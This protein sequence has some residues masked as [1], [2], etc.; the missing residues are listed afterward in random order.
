VTTAVLVLLAVWLLLSAANQ[1]NGPWTRLLGPLNSVSLLP[2]LFFF[3]PDP[4]DVDYHLVFRDFMEDGEAGRWQQIPIER[5]GPWRVLW[6]TAKR[7]HQAM[8]LAVAGLAGLQQTVTPVARDPEGL[9]QVSIPY[10]F[11][12]HRV[13][14]APRPAGAQQRQFMV[15][16]TSGFRPRRRVALGILSNPHRLD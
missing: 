9:I 11:L 10:L 16:E 7:D 5:E 8:T 1:I 3:A 4:V 15:V 13:L 2:A 6:C 12:L 14:A